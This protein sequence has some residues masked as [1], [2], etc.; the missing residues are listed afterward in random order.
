MDKEKI[1]T[2]QGVSGGVLCLIIALC[3]LLGLTSGY[4]VHD[5]ISNKQETNKEAENVKPT[6]NTNE[7]N[8]VVEETK[9]EVMTK[10]EDKKAENT[11][12]EKKSASID[13]TNEC[14]NSKNNC[15]K[16]YELS[17]GEINITINTKMDN[18]KSQI[19]SINGKE[20][21]THEI[22]DIYGPYQ[23]NGIAL[24]DNNILVLDINNPGYSG[25]GGHI[26]IFYDADSNFKEINRINSNKY[27]YDPKNPKKIESKEGTYETCEV[28]TCDDQVKRTYSYTINDNKKIT[29][30]LEKEENQFCS[31]QC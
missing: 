17:N 5:V 7:D 6:K 9:E 14:I 11:K 15:Q 26:R 19:V 10:T 3:L 25:P 20:I 18:T 1:K 4:I 31:A 2:K 22:N 12:T 16:E 30:K 29:S 24:L 8:K 28:K 13:L 21:Y 23:I 27:E